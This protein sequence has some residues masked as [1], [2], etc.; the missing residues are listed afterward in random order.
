[1]IQ[2]ING[3]T[4]KAGIILDTRIF[5]IFN[6]LESAIAPSIIPPVAVISLTIESDMID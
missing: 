5:L 4:K 1:M 3:V 2:T 6:K